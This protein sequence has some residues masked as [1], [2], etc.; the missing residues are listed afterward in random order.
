M[1]QA[2]DPKRKRATT[3]CQ[4]SC[5][6]RELGLL[7]PS[8]SPQQHQ[9]QQPRT[10]TNESIA[11]PNKSKLFLATPATKS[12]LRHVRY[13]P[14]CLT[15]SSSSYRCDDAMIIHGGREQT[16]KAHWPTTPGGGGQ[17]TRLS[18]SYRAICCRWGE[19]SREASRARHRCFVIHGL[20]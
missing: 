11:T 2:I 6:K 15:P 20:I 12:A 16:D 13:S 9:Q 19:V 5:R 17:V 18:L 3:L 4:H 14:R 7:R 1:A 10:L 8:A